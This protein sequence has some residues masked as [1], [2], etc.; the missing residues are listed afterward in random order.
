MRLHKGHDS[1]TMEHVKDVRFLE[2]YR[3]RMRI[4]EPLYV[5]IED[6]RR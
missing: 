5:S 3:L 1:L 2:D 6:G 4:A